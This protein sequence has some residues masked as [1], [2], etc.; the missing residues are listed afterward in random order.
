MMHAVNSQEA[1]HTIQKKVSWHLF[2]SFFPSFVTM[3]IEQSLEEESSVLCLFC[4]FPFQCEKHF[5]TVRELTPSECSSVFRQTLSEMQQ[6]YIPC[7]VCIHL[8][9]FSAF[10]RKKAAAHFL[11]YVV[12]CF[13][14]FFV[15][16]RLEGN[17]SHFFSW[18]CI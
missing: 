15:T 12:A 9:L 7:Q 2:C 8:S 14:T 10:I 18:L 1:L 5:H 13:N 4:Y 11:I 6:T 17:Q 3:L 16:L